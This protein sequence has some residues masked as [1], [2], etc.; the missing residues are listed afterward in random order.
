MPKAQ[1]TLMIIPSLPQFL[2]HLEPHLFLLD[3]GQRREVERLNS[4]KSQ[5]ECASIEKQRDMM[6]SW[7][8]TLLPFHQGHTGDGQS[9]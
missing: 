5:R 2:V 3:P 6:P 7:W 8:L 4:D 1:S 9:L